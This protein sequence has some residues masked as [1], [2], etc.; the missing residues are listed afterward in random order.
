[1]NGG[2]GRPMDGF[3]GGG[4]PGGQGG[5][6]PGGG[7]GNGGPGGGQGGFNGGGGPSGNQNGGADGGGNRPFGGMQRGGGGFGGGRGGG[8]TSLSGDLWVGR[9]PEIFTANS[10]VKNDR[11]EMALVLAEQVLPSGN[12]LF[13]S[14]VERL[15]SKNQIPL[16]S[17]LVI[18]QNGPGQP[19][20]PPPGG[21]N[22]DNQGPPPPQ[23]G[24][25]P[26]R[27]WAKWR[28]AAGTTTASAAPCA[29]NDCDGSENHQHGRHAVR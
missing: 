9:A 18:A 10:G 25:A 6:F 11:E 26:Q 28:P 27:Q 16:K 21:G 29:G 22:G 8:G 24:D 5:G 7:P 17:N 3:Q 1:M 4:G 15:S 14:F 19:P 12:P 13:K 20:P 23:N 2:G